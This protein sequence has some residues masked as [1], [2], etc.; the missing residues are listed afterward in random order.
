[1]PLAAEGRQQGRG[2]AVLHEPGARCCSTTAA[3]RSLA[4]AVPDGPGELPDYDEGYFYYREY[5]GAPVDAEGKP[6]YHTLPASWE[7]AKTD[8]ERWRWALAQAVENSP[9]RLNAVRFQL[10]QFFEQQFGVQ[11]MAQRPWRRPR[12]LARRRTTTRRRTKAAPT[13][14]TR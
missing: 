1:M 7:A 5:N 10:A 4:A 12:L 8:G 6:V 14:C 2:L 3:S 9:N 13:P 11:T